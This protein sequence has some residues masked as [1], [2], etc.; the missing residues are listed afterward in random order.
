MIKA[1]YIQFHPEL[2]NID[3]NIKRL[4]PF[5]DQ[6]KGADLIVLPELVSTG[7]NFLKRE[8]AMACAEELKTSRFLEYLIAKAKQNNAFIVAGINEKMGV[9]TMWKVVGLVLTIGGTVG[10]V[11]GFLLRLLTGK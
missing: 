6:A 8:D 1:G 10:G 11:V 7:Y 5:I 2:G 9:E 4:D 3:S